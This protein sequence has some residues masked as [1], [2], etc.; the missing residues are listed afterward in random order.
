[1]TTIVADIRSWAWPENMY[2]LIVATTILD[3]LPYHDILITRDRIAGALKPNSIVFVQ[4]HTVDDPAVSGN[5]VP[6]EFASAIK[7]YFGWNELLDLFRPTFRVLYYSERCEWDYDH[8]SPHQHGFS[9]L[10]GK[11]AGKVQI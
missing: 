4:V 9:V 10:I 1:M 2:D 7:H 3:H 11:T 8:G 6:S 5:G